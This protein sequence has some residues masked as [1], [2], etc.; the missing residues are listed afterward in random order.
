MELRVIFREILDR[1][2]GMRPAGEPEMLRSNFIGGIKHFPVR[3]SP[4]KR[5]NPLGR[6]P[7]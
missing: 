6:R 5:V 2:A 3:F 4:G 1:V 7:L